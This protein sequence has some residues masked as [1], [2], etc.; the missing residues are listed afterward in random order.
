MTKPA[1][2]PHV[3]LASFLLLALAGCTGA[4]D[5]GTD[6]E[7]RAQEAALTRCPPSV[8]QSLA[9]PAGNRL[10]F[11]V[12]AAGEQLY[13]C[14]QTATGFGWVFKPGFEVDT[15]LPTGTA[16]AAAGQRYMVLKVAMTANDSLSALQIDSHVDD[17]NLNTGV[18][19]YRKGAVDTLKFLIIPIS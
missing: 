2:N 7:A 19:R 6:S 10:A 15:L 14:Q 11:S 8:P 17:G 4:I 3:R 16:S 9:V 18:V 13:A 5:P 12:D 1:L